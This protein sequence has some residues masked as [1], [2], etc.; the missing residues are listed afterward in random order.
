M[1]DMEQFSSL[2]LP[3][4]VLFQ[5]F[6]AL[7]IGKSNQ[8]MQEIAEKFSEEIAKLNPKGR[9]HDS[10]LGKHSPLGQPLELISVDPSFRGR[11]RNVENVQPWSM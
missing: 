6:D 9:A 5:A 8:T 10:R 2:S 7:P 3:E 11:K 1:H 4:D